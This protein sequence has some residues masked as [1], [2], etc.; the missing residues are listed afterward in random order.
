MCRSLGFGSCPF[1]SPRL[2]TVA[3][4]LRLRPYRFPCAFH[5]THVRLAKQA[6]SLVRFSKRTTEHRLLSSPT[7]GSPQIRSSRGLLCPVALSPTDF[8]TYCTA[9]LG[10]L[11]SVR[12]RYLFAI[13]L[14]K[15]LVFAV[16]ARE[17]HEGYPT[18][19]TLELTRLVLTS[20]TGL[21][22]CFILRS[23]RFQ[24]DGLRV[25]VSPNT[26][27]PEGFGLDCVAFTRRY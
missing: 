2:N 5:D 11:F 1:D 22:P 16:D 12:S 15:C 19:A 9:L 6:H 10:V 17:I 18:P 14:E 4:V 21:S 20:L 25:R 3:L 23:R 7:T 24:R 26:T 27:L 13:G 8:K